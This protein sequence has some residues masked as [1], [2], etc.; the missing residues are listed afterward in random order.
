MFLNCVII[1]LLC[2]IIIIGEYCYCCFLFCLLRR[3][4]CPMLVES[5]VDSGM[6]VCN[7]YMNILTS[8]MRKTENMILQYL[9]TIETMSL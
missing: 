8:Q 4:L 5:S 1:S 9:I 6:Q 3:F 2:I 7:P